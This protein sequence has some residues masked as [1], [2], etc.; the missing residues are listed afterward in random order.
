ME[1]YL[2]I[3]QPWKNLSGSNVLFSFKRLI[4]MS[5]HVNLELTT[6]FHKI[7]APNLS[8]SVNHPSYIF[9]GLKGFGRETCCIS[10]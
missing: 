4:P 9:S 10:Q 5:R 7:Q 1:H 3:A 8:Y 2:A 6:L